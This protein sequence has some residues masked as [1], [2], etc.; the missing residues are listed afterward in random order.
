MRPQ[1]KIGFSD[2]NVDK[3][4]WAAKEQ[5]CRNDGPSSH[6][7]VDEHGVLYRGV[8][9]PQASSLWDKLRVPSNGEKKDFWDDGHMS[10][11]Y[12]RVMTGRCVFQYANNKKNIQDDPLEKKVFHEGNENL[13]TENLE[14]S[15]ILRLL[16]NCWPVAKDPVPG[17]GIAD[18]NKAFVFPCV[19]CSSK[20]EN[21]L[22]EIVGV[23]LFWQASPRGDMKTV[24]TLS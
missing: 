13:W 24:T 2:V 11:M 21:C 1:L 15:K 12:K 16:H 20:P 17:W 4:D 3:R 23:V 10:G 18:D 6:D 8:L 7:L 5:L 22:Q 19:Q 9:I 14:K